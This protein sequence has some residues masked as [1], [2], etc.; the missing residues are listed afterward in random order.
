MK[1]QMVINADDVAQ[2]IDISNPHY[3][4]IYYKNKACVVNVQDFD[5][6]DYSEF[7]SDICFEDEENAQ[8]AAYIMNDF[9]V[10][11]FRDKSN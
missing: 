11:Y 8:Q 4:I 3:R 9:G 7:I 1:I 10:E 5:Y 6:Y 2:V